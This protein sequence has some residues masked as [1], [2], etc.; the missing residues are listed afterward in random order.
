MQH[1]FWGRTGAASRRHQVGG[2]PDDVV[3]PQ[4]L[5]GEYSSIS[6][7]LGEARRE[8][9]RPQASWPSSFP[10]RR[11]GGEAI[12]HRASQG[13]PRRPSLGRRIVPE[14]FGATVGSVSHNCPD[15]RWAG[16]GWNFSVV[17]PREC[18]SFV[19]LH[20]WPTKGV[21]RAEVAFASRGIRDRYCTAVYYYLSVACV[22]VQTGIRCSK[23][24]TPHE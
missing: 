12:R 20:V 22:G 3:Q 4:L 2:M 16:P 15:S 24:D 11:Y 17:W 8:E 18:L 14:L 13:W 9:R 5:G 1:W 21:V 7:L 19:C 10:V 23:L 6:F